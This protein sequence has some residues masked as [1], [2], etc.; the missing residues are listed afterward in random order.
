LQGG[1]VDDPIYKL[2]FDLRAITLSIKLSKSNFDLFPVIGSFGIY[3]FSFFNWSF[4]CSGSICSISGYSGA[5]GLKEI[6]ITNSIPFVIVKAYLN[7][8]IKL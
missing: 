4:Q 3:D 5:S 2:K 7:I 6:G 1:V 8:S